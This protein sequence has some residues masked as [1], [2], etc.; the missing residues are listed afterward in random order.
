MRIYLSRFVLRVS[1]PPVAGGAVAVDDGKV[2]DVGRA[3]DVRKRAG[4]DD[5]VVDLGDAVLM[6]GVVNAHTHLELSFFEDDPPAGGDWV[7][8]VRRLVERRAEAD[9]VA[10]RAGIERGVATLRSRGT[11]AVGDVANG[12]AT[13]AALA[14]SGLHAVVFHELYGLRPEDAEAHVRGAAERLE[15]MESEVEEAGGSE[16][17]RLALSPHAPHTTSSALLKALAGRAAAADA[18]LSVHAAESEDEVRFLRDGTGAA[19]EYFRERGVLPEDWSPPRMTPVAYLDRL[20]VLSPHTLLVHAVHL[21]QQD[22]SRLQTRGVTVVVCPRS[23]ATLGVGKAAVPRILAAGIPVALGT[24][25]LASAPD[26]DLFAEMAALRDDHPALPPAA[27]VRMATSNGA[28]ALG[29]GHRLGAIEP[30]FDAALVAVPLAAPD[31]D[32]LETVTSRPERVTVLEVGAEIAG[33]RA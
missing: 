9:D 12:T 20:G 22:L 19:A 8:W 1:A 23:N 31:D 27:V 26:L 3:A 7:R 16:R 32:P 6:P 2:V 5:E 29:L 24:D 14:R 10:I 4:A 15:R 11:V 30:G 18:P 13:A 21:E 17:V 33:D 25:S 28:R